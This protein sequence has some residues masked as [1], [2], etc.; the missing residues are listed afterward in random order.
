MKYVAFQIG[1]EPMR[2][3]EEPSCCLPTVAVD[4]RSPTAG[5]TRTPVALDVA[6]KHLEGPGVE[7]GLE[8][9][10][11]ALNFTDLDNLSLSDI[12]EPAEE[13]ALTPTIVAPLAM[14]ETLDLT[15]SMIIPAAPS[16][17]STPSRT[18]NKSLS[19]SSKARRGSDENSFSNGK[20]ST[21]SV[22]SARNRVPFGYVVYPNQSKD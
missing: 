16:I 22:L 9:L 14:E 1:E 3:F 8:G 12:E 15:S 11:Q 2:D 21:G 18:P 17:T 19:S 20:N 7:K 5:I 13:E 4:P 10:I 6:A